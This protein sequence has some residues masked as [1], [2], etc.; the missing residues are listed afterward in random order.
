MSRRLTGLGFC[1]CATLLFAAYYLGASIFS[2]REYGFDS[3]L[4]SWIVEETYAWL[5]PVFAGVFF[6][7]G[8]IYLIV[9]EIRGDK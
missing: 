4:F 1:F 3:V 2:S 8:I 6:I 7:T 9:A 5:L